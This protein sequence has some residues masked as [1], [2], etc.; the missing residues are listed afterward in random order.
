MTNA[1]SNNISFNE[2]KSYLDAAYATVEGIKSMQD[3]DNMDIR[4]AY[5][6]R[7]SLATAQQVILSRD[8]FSPEE[9][10]FGVDHAVNACL[11]KDMDELFDLFECMLEGDDEDKDEFFA[12]FIERTKDHPMFYAAKQK[13]EFD[14]IHSAIEAVEEALGDE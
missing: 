9:K 11:C 14:L 13:S 8:I 5:S 7:L 6:T 1:R 10:M 2:S 12:W 3:L 4:G